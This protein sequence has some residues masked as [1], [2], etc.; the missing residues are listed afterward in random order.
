MERERKRK[1][2]RKKEKSLS[3][4]RLFV[5]PWTVAYQAPLSMRFI[6]A[7]VLEWVAIQHSVNCSYYLV[8]EWCTHMA[9][10][11]SK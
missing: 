9:V 4:V 1:R 10:A 5:T 11:K 6:Q 8:K 3:H 7:R 2:E